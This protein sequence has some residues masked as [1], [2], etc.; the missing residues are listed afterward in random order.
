M[1][2]WLT[3][4][5]LTWPSQLL[6]DVGLLPNGGRC[7]PLLPLVAFKINT[8]PTA[9]GIH[10]T[11]LIALNHPFYISC[12]STYWLQC[13]DWSLHD[14]QEMPRDLPERTSSE[15]LWFDGGERREA[16]PGKDPGGGGISAG[17]TRNTEVREMSLLAMLASQ[18]AP[19]PRLATCCHLLPAP[20]TCR[21]VSWSNP[22]PK[23]QSFIGL[24][25]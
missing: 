1:P 10:G 19:D 2:L 15:E 17:P 8:N 11:H 12:L 24:K 4:G 18:A 20:L 21:T 6:W 14:P 7:P 22:E 25:I 5:S 23:F 16:T 9:I 13:I 3:G